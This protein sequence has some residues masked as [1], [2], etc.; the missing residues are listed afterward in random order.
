MKVLPVPVSIVEILYLIVLCTVQRIV[1]GIR[2]FHG[3]ASMP[4]LFLKILLMVKLKRDP[5][6][7]ID[8]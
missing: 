4:F 7:P 3:L 1:I 2:Q 8:L 6:R 5:L